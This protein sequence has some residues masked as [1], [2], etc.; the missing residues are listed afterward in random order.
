MKSTDSQNKPVPIRVLCF[1]YP[2]GTTYWM[3]DPSDKKMQDEIALWKSHHPE[4]EG[5]GVSMA[6][7]EINM[8]PDDYRHKLSAT[9]RFMRRHIKINP[10]Q[11]D[12]DD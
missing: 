6:V 5:T 7:A 8:L 4:Y 1:V 9:N 2:D 12:A 11:N 10:A 3:D